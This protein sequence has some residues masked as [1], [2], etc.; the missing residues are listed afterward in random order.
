MQ[1]SQRK[2]AS[3][4]LAWGVKGNFDPYEWLDLDSEVL[5]EKSMT[6]GDSLIEF[7]LNWELKKTE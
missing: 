3:V 7:M 2:M 4:T 1:R 6:V 5:Y